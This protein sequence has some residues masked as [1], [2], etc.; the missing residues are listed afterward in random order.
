M[1]PATIQ[2]SLACDTPGC[3]SYDFLEFHRLG[4]DRRSVCK[5]HAT[6]AELA[7]VADLDQRGAA[8]WVPVG[9]Y[10]GMANGWPYG[11]NISVPMRRALVEWAEPR[12]LRLYTG[13]DAC[14]HW[15][16]GEECHLPAFACGPT[17]TMS[18][19]S[20]FDHPT[21]WTRASHPALL[22]AQPYDLT[23]HDEF[24]VSKVEDV[25]Q[26]ELV[27]RMHPGGYYAAGF[28]YP[29]PGTMA[30]ELWSRAVLD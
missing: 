30:V 25:H 21:A 6:D 16:L 27:V 18:I 14:I 4:E 26:G 22:L 3:R 7:E 23:Q 20:W 17:G 24:V 15:L 5:R 19:P 2:S 11:P 29:V 1:M 10:G 9:G 13:D 28:D 8:L 12:Q